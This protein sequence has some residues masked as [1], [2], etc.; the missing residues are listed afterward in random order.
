MLAKPMTAVEFEALTARLWRFMQEDIYPNEQRFHEESRAMESLPGEMWTH[1]QVLLE[2]MDKAKEFGLWNLWLP[3]DTAQIA[4][5]GFEGAGLNNEQY[6]ELCE[7]M[8]T[9]SHMEFAAQATNCSSPDTGNME[10]IARFG[11]ANQKAMW[12][13]PLLRGEIRSAF[14]MTEPEVASSDATNISIRIERKNG[15]FI[16]NGRKWWITGAGSAHCKILIVMGKT[17]P[18][19]SKFK[20]QSMI[21]VPTSTPGIT[22]VRPLQTMGDPEAPKGHMEILFE[23][24]CVP[25]GN[26]L[27][28]EGRGFEIAQ[29]RLGPGRI[30]HCMRL[31]GTAERVLS[32]MCKRVENR[33]AFGKRLAQFD[34]I[35]QDI[36]KSRS[37]IDQARMLVRHTAR[38][39]DEV[40]NQRARKELSMCKAVVPKMVQ[41]VCDRAMQA[42]GAMGICQD[43]CLPVAFNSARWLRFADGPDEVHWRT[44]ARLELNQQKKSI[45]HAIPYY[46]NR[47]PIHKKNPPTDE[48]FLSKL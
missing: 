36:A 44:V 20:Q 1:P 27:A 12:L 15:F 39:L 14:A 4:G 10:T 25:E 38:L 35:L 17:S 32:T 30:H 28:G 19:A 13:G 26:V 3:S 11:N 24:V 37:E 9:A 47:A 16:I 8:G 31:I 40:G 41:T 23:N 2:L 18:N 7:I 29:A 45:L 33:T 22:F 48:N 21:L 46:E 5:Q 42:H 43:S 34:T 6:A